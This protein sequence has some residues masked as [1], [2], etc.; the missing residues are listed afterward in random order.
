MF[1]RQKP[2]FYSIFKLLALGFLF[3]QYIQNLSAQDSINSFQWAGFKQNINAN[4]GFGNNTS[5]ALEYPTGSGKS[6][7][8]R[9]NIWVTAIKTNGDTIAI[10]SDIFSKNTNWFPGPVSETAPVHL[11]SKQW[12][13]FFAVSESEIANHK[14][15]FNKSGYLCPKAIEK[16]PSAIKYSGFTEVCAPFVDFDQNGHY[17]ALLGDYPFVPGKN[18]VFTMASDSALL[19]NTKKH[20]TQLDL[21]AIWFEP[22]N[23]DSAPNT[24]FAR[25]TICNRGLDSFKNL[26]L[27]MQG[28]FQIGSPLD[29]ELATNVKYGSIYAFNQPGGDAVYGNDWPAVALGWLSTKASASINMLPDN[30]AV[31]GKPTNEREF[32]HYA[33]G[34]WRSGKNM[35]S[36][37]SGLDASSSV[38]KFIYPGTTDPSL[39][40]GR[41]WTNSEGTIGRQTAIISTSG[42]QLN[43]K[44]CK[45]VDGFIS[46][47]VHAPDSA[48]FENSLANIHKFYNKQDYQLKTVKPELVNAI[49]FFPNPVKSG[50]LL[51][52]KATENFNLEIWDLSGKLVKCVLVKEAIY[53]IDLR[54]GIYIIRSAKLKPQKLQVIE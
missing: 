26:K 45:V 37:G 8:K 6:P 5:N 47:I 51:R 17:A 30:S 15:N 46:V 7:L 16:W 11:N 52:F 9:L 10:G 4:G 43:G 48:K 53:R 23:G 14:L 32:Y 20:Q 1:H 3:A 36:G 40:K 22:V 44:T 21:S 2:A 34:F 25:F 38:S 39:P 49:S 24:L 19:W 33:N 12:I 27:T 31:Q 54:P 41:N 13:P 50:N 35:G 18:N 42:M 28:D 29:D